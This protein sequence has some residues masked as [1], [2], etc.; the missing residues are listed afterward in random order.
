MDRGV[1]HRG[2][3]CGA[4]HRSDVSLRS[5]QSPSTAIL[6]FEACRRLSEPPEVASGL[7]L[8]VALVGLAANAGSLVLLR[9]A[10]RQSLNMRGLPRRPTTIGL[11]WT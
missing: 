5:A 11:R 1:R 7:M 8:A 2:G 9:D 4:S 3:A 10:Q 6:L